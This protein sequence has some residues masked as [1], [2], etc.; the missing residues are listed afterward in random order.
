MF[1][2]TTIASS[3]TMPV[4]RM[5]PKSVSVLIEKPI[6]FT[7]ANAPTSETGIVIAGISVLRQFCRKTKMT[8]T[9]RTIASTSV[10]STSTIDAS[11]TSVVL[12][13]TR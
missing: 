7:N 10:F 1:S 9:T 12:N 2:M 3:T 11:T 5:M 6:S 8:S 13:E 4:A